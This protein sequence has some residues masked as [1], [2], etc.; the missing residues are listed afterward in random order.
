MSI[1]PNAQLIALICSAFFFL[2]AD[3]P[4]IITHPKDRS[5]STGA[6]ITF[7]VETTGDELQFQWQKD[8]ADIGTSESRFSFSQ[9][10]HSSTLQIR[11]L[12]KSDEGHY[13]CVVKNPVEQRGKPSSE[14]ELKV[15]KY[16]ATSLWKISSNIIIL[17]PP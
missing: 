6:D 7:T 14:A 10:D 15:C 12:A 5:V 11:C 1:A 3:P 9:T 2:S 16:V 17:Y 8:G 13:K 4:K